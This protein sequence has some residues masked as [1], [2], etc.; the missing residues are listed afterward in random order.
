MVQNPQ[1]A[2]S[3]AFPTNPQPQSQVVVVGRL[4]AAATALAAVATVD[5]RDAS[6]LGL[7]HVLQTTPSAW[8]QAEH[9]AQHH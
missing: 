8:F 2:A 4:A 3:A 1:T 9:R 6:V 7:S 5:V